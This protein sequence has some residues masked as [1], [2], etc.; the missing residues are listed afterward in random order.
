MKKIASL[1][2]LFLISGCLNSNWI[3]LSK[4]AAQFPATATVTKD[5][6]T[7]SK[8]SKGVVIVGVNWGRKWSCGGFENAQL[9]SIGFDNLAK[10]SSENT[11]PPTLVMNTPSMIYVD[12]R[13]FINYA[14]LVDPGVYAISNIQIK[15]AKSIKEIGFINTIKNQL[16]EN[17]NPKGGTFTVSPNEVVYIGNFWLDC[18]YQPML[19]RYYQMS[20]VFDEF[21]KEYPF[22]PLKNVKYD[23]F[24]TDVYGNGFDNDYK[25]KK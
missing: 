3:P 6:Y 12:N 5:S 15:A 9:T 13:E 8:A 10:L 23:L 24:K 11:L 22:L 20:T 17:N 16:I 4:E 1:L 14:F 19:W 7:R 21:A 25:P 18:Y 2:F